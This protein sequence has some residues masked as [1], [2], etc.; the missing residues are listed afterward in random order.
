MAIKGQTFQYYPFSLKAEA[1]QLYLKGLTHRQITEQLNIS[2]PQRV[3]KWMR[4][5]RERGIDGLKD[6]R[7]NPKPVTEVQQKIQRLELENEV[8][9]K[10]L[11][12]LNREGYK[13][14]TK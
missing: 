13:R 1:V 14:N 12:I 9:K 8:L 3:K 2:D 10:W 11:Q 5:Y 6:G 4:I 7:G